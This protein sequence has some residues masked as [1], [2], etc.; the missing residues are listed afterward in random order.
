MTLAR[1]GAWLPLRACRASVIQIPV[2]RTKHHSRRLSLRRS[3]TALL[4]VALCATVGCVQRR[5]TVRSNPPG[6][7]VYIDNYP[8]GVTPVSTDFTYYGKRQF[9]LVRDGYETLTVDQKVKAPWY[10]WFGLDFV[11]ENLVP[12]TIRDEQQFNFQ[13]VPQQVPPREQLAARAEELRAST[14]AQRYVPPP[15][16]VVPAAGSPAPPPPPP[17]VVVPPPGQPYSLPAPGGVPPAGAR[18]APPSP[19]QPIYSVPPTSNAFSNPAPSMEGPAMGSPGMNAPPAGHPAMPNYQVPP[20]A[21]AYGT[22]PN[23]GYST[24]SGPNYGTPPAGYSNPSAPSNSPYSIYEPPQGYGPSAAPQGA[25]GT[26]YPGT[27]TPS[28]NR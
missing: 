8:I 10:E 18:V 9:R 6:A 25:P 11:S 15:V 20:P 28:S 13:M 26:T 1:R 12:Y 17:G 21:S 5:M 22:P 14:Q 16:P 3:C 23:A 2:K 24:P 4:A 19:G 27:W 7:Y